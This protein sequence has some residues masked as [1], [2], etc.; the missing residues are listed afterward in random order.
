MEY[1]LADCPAEERDERRK[2]RFALDVEKVGGDVK[3]AG[4]KRAGKEA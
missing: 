2:G 4:T 3:T 1:C